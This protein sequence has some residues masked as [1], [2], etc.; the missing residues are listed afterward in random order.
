MAAQVFCTY[1]YRS[2]T[3]DG[4]AMLAEI[5]G[6]RLRTKRPPLNSNRLLFLVVLLF[7]LGPGIFEGDCPVENWLAGF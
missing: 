5:P 3:L 6:M 4:L 7:D 2:T 1:P